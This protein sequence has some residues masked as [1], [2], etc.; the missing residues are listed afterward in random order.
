[1]QGDAF[2]V[3]FGEEARFHADCLDKARNRGVVEDLLK[4]VAGRPLQLN[5]RI[6]AR[7]VGAQEKASPEPRRRGDARSRA[8][9]E[10]AIS[11]P[12]VREIVK[13][14]DGRLVDVRA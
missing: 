11:D 14:F 13:L 3:V 1:M 5:T 8:A 2:V 7:P 9:R 4:A 12:V 6:E 10:R